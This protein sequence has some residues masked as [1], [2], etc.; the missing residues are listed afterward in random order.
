MP[1]IGTAGV[2]AVRQANW[3]NLD[4]LSGTATGIVADK[5]GES[6]PTSVTVEW[7][8]NNTWCSTG[9]GEENNQL[10][11]Y[12]RTLM[13]GYLDTAAATTST[14]T[15]QGLPAD[16]TAEGYDVYVYLLG[17][18][19]QKGGGYRI[20]NP[21]S[22]AILKDT[23]LAQCSVNPTAHVQAVPAAGSP[24]VGTY[25]L[26]TG[27]TAGSIRVEASTADGLGFGTNPRAPINAIQLVPTGSGVEPE[28]PEFTAIVLNA[29]GTLTVHWTGGGTLQAAPTVNGP[30]QDVAGAA[31]PYT[32]TPTADMLF[33]RIVK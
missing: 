16:L 2:P 29:D 32:F 18:V 23:V 10:T 4:L 7:N 9:R 13:T 22:G 1:S 31:S 15:I 33:G 12:N 21:A 5:R 27:L 11:G 3:N 20:V 8:S 6:W 28:P 19:A 14:V 30:W 26:F 24:G 17:G 25:V